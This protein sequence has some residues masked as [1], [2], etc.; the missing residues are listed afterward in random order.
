MLKR[1]DKWKEKYE[2]LEKKYIESLREKQ[3]IQNEICQCKLALQQEM[4]NR[5][6]VNALCEQARRTK[7]DMR[8]HLFVLAAFLNKNEIDNAKEYTSSILDKLNLDYT[9]IST[10]NSLLNYIINQKLNY[11]S[12]QKIYVKAEIENLKFEGISSIDFSAILTNILD[13]A[14]EAGGKSAKRYMEVV[15]RKN[16]GYE[17]IKVCNSIDKS[18]LADNPELLT[19]K[20]ENDEHGVGILN[21]RELVEKYKGILDI[22]E[23]ENKFIV[24]VMFEA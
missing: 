19:T 15:I 23:E 24:S 14:I 4:R 20:E 21:V 2:E 1:N 17:M 13:N 3:V 8:N 22:Y 12:E 18:V 6:E 11:A 5:K 7:H 9:Y 16:R 10:G